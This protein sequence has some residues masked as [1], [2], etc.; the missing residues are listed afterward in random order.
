MLKPMVKF[1]P[2]KNLLFARVHD[3][4]LAT[5]RLVMISLET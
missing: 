4:E 3:S 2:R 1:L 5:V